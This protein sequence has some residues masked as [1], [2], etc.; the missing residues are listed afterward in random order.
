MDKV[1][2]EDLMDQKGVV[3]MEEKEVAMNFLIF[4]I[5][6]ILSW[7]QVMVV[8]LMIA[9]VVEEGVSLLITMVQYLLIT[10]V[11]N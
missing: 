7:L 5:W 3:T 11:N 10:R 4:P 9:V 6:S 8:T 1:V 2:K